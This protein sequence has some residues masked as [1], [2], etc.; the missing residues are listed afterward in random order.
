M[1]LRMAPNMFQDKKYGAFTVRS[2]REE[3]VRT[4]KF[5]DKYPWRSNSAGS[6]RA[7]LSS[8]PKILEIESNK[9]II[10]A[11]II[12]GRT[13]KK[14]GRRFDLSREDRELVAWALALNGFVISNDQDI[15]DYGHQEFSGLFMG[16][17]S[18]L[19]ILNDWLEEG[20]LTW[21]DTLQCYL[22][23]WKT[24]SEKPQ[25]TREKRRFNKLTGYQYVGS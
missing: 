20:L 7:L 14:T 2:I 17:L 12:S 11:Q 9:K 4:S 23:D 8:H 21:D 6:I 18:P 1:L 13:N 15:E 24:N 5:K 16:R 22:D 19:E 25:P 10:D 3:F